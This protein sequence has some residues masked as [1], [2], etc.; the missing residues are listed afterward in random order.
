MDCP[1][2]KWSSARSSSC[3]DCAAGSW[4]GSRSASCT[5]CAAGKFG[6]TTG[7]SN[8]ACSGL[9]SA[10]HYC[11]AG[12][13][14]ATQ[15][16]C[17]VGTNNSALGGTSSAAC[18]NCAAGTYN[19]SPGAAECK[20]CPAG[21]YGATTGL[22]NLAC[23]G[24]CFAGYHCPAGSTSAT[25]ITCAVGTYVSLARAPAKNKRAP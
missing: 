6:A 20:L 8:P 10:G 25:Q 18:L 11:P 19:D 4:S 12:S 23:S 17:A 7:L 3:T 2:G 1:A 13:A 21:T 22:S 15:I 5:N 16:A 9:C 24:L 14:N